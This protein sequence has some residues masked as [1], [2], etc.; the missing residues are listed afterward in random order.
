MW[1]CLAYVGA[2]V[3]VLFPAVVAAFNRTIIP[4]T[5]NLCLVVPEQSSWCRDRPTCSLIGA[6]IIL[7][8]TTFASL[9]RAVAVIPRGRCTLC[10]LAQSYLHWHQL[11]L[12]NDLR[13]PCRRP[14]LFFVH[15][16][17][18]T[19]STNSRL[20]SPPTYR[21]RLC[22]GK[23]SANV[24]AARLSCNHSPLPP[25]NPKIP[26]NCRPYSFRGPV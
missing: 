10:R 5:L 8:V 20:S 4:E 13:T 2:R 7:L 19:S 16:N 26:P 21:N 6:K 17:R 15:D 23:Q 9:P 12:T 11:L 24:K 14:S 25:K 3:L 18:S 22:C 1:L